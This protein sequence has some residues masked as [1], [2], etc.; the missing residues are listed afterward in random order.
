MF[1]KTSREY[2]HRYQKEAN[3]LKRLCDG[4]EQGLDKEVA[5]E[6]YERESPFQ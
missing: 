5:I 4:L 2:A 3:L 6:I 1:I